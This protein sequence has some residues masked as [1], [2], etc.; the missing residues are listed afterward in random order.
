[1]EK[2]EAQLHNSALSEENAQEEC[3]IKLLAELQHRQSA[4]NAAT[5]KLLE[6]TVINLLRT[7]KHSEH[8]D[9]VYK[10]LSHIRVIL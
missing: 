7:F 9:G 6:N 4:E 3:T 5:E 1:M 8:R 10:E 2:T